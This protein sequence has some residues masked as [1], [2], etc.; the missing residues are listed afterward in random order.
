MVENEN[1]IQYHGEAEEDL[2]HVPYKGHKVICRILSIKGYCAWGQKVGQEFIV[3]ANS[4]GGLCGYLH[5]MIYPFIMVLEFGGNFPESK[6]WGGDRMEFTCPDAIN[7]TRVQLRRE[8]V[9]PTRHIS[10]L[11]DEEREERRWR[12]KLGVEKTERG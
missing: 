4:P 7:V 11:K 9:D 1:M 12:K 2:K 5:H 10:Y 3:S 8:G 6:N